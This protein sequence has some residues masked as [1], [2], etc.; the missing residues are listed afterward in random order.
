MRDSYISC[1]FVYFIFTLILLQFNNCP[2]KI[3]EKTYSVKKIVINTLDFIK[4][5]SIIK[6]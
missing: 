1:V 6:S 5:H 2:E 4:K 3:V